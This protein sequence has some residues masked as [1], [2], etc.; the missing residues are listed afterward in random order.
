MPKTAKN[1]AFLFFLEKKVLK[2]FASIKNGSNFAT[3]FNGD[4]V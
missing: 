2:K 4:I 3:L 1:G